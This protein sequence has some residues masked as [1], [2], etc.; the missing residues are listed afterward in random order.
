MYEPKYTPTFNKCVKKYRDKKKQI[1][2]LCR[3]ICEDP[4]CNSH[5]LKKKGVDLQ[6]KRSR[7]LTGNLVMIFIVCDECI[8]ESFHDKGYNN[9]S[10]CKNKALQRVIFVAFDK[11]E[12]IYSKEWYV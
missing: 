7:H 2:K 6:G 5:L 12:S 3:K 9:C 11:H 8:K 1:E 4:F 10:F